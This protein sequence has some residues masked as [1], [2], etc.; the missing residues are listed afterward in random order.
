MTES[1]PVVLEV[2]VGAPI[3]T[4]WASLR[5]PDLIKL[6]HGWH[7]D[8]LDDEIT[9]IYG[10]RVEADESAYTLQLGDGDRFE[11]T[12]AEAGTVVRI[13]RAPYVPG[14]EW[15][16]YYSEITEGWLSFLQQLKFMHEQHPGE[17]RR[18][19]FFSG[20]GEA[21]ALPL[22]VESLPTRAG[23]AAFTAAHQRGVVLPELGPGLLIVAAKPAVVD[24]RGAQTADAMAIITTYGLPEKEF[25]A[26][27][28]RWTDWWRTAYPAS[29]PA[30]V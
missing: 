10:D 6:W 30:Q 13:V 20:S 18:T 19:I 27:V 1:E 12:E 15:S 24:E 29:D 14:T 23:E 21:G 4:V 2:T 9:V 11:L 17:S 5:D 26:E 3:G 28:D 16:A 25:A 8:Q 22:L 7:Y